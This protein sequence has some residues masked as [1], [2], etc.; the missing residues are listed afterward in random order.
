MD[1]R[2]VDRKSELMDD[3]S[4]QNPG[5]HADKVPGSINSTVL[6]YNA[7]CATETRLEP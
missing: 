7:T 4:H 1:R 3:E 6:G 2:T 5:I